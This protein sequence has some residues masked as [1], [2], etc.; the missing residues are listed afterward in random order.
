MQ[1]AIRTL[2]WVKSP[3][4]QHGALFDVPKFTTVQL[5]HFIPKSTT[6]SPHRA[7]KIVPTHSLNLKGRMENEILLHLTCDMSLGTA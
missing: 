3:A 4:G 2:G 6:H 5:E 1:F 7:L